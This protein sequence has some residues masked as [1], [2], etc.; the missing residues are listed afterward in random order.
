MSDK[1]EEYSRE[2][3]LRLIRER[4]RKPS[5]GLVWERKEIEH[6]R[7][8]NND[9]VMLEHDPLLSEGNGPH[10]NL[11]IEGDNFDAL[12]YLRMTHAGKVKCIYIDPP[13]NTGNKD[14]IYNDRF[15]DKDDVYKHSKW[16]EFMYRRL[17]IAKDLLANN[18]V[19]LVSINDENKAKLELLM[20]G[21]FPQMRL[22]SLVWR[23]K[24]TGNDLSQRYS[25]VHEHVL[26]YAT[27]QFRF[28]GKPTDRSKFRNPDSDPRGDWSP[29]P[30]TKAHTFAERGN[31]YYPIQNPET[32]YWY[33]CDPNRV[34][35]YASEN[36]IRK[37]VNND[38]V[39]LK[40]AL[41]ALRSDS[42]EKLIEKNLIYFPPCKTSEVMFFN[43]RDELIKAIRSGKGPALPKKKT[44]LLSEDLPD[45]DFWVGKP[46]A[47]GR[48]SRKE[49]WSAKPEE[50]R[51][52][53][54]CSWIGGVNEDL[55]DL[56]DEDNDH[57]VLRTT[58]GGVATE[59]VKDI[60]G[61][62]AFQH[63]KPLSLLEGLL[64]QSAGSDDLVMDF[65][66]GSG[67]T[68]HALMKLNAIDGGNRRFILV[69]SSEATADQPQKN[70]C[71]D[72][73]AERLRRVIVGYTNKKSETVD[74]LGSEFAYMRTKRIP[75]SQVFNEI[76]HNQVW[77]A[78]QLIHDLPLADFDEKVA[79][80]VAGNPD[81]HV[82]YLAKLEERSLEQIES[83]ANTGGL[84]TL[85]SWQPAQL[86]QRIHSSNVSFEKIP[87]FL[88]KRFGGAA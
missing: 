79:L 10:Q 21:V 36:E 8:I 52:A 39:S 88:V 53:P 72:V 31:T 82:V 24:D 26:V 60:L 67:T 55:D 78:L 12:R 37:R 35:A 32:G 41:E 7:S 28:N 57:E 68:G 59:E 83:V 18:G 46:I 48:P 1:Y 16:L 25:H 9:F 54:L 64:A 86:R 44:Q 81:K 73:C 47:T 2:E 4:D 77:R 62:K 30:L 27:P 19:I 13:Y 69:S 70:I 50:E 38:E 45:L 66:A 15:I 61:F 49:L 65:F 75:I 17:V 3:L 63:P 43:S 87:E 11:V 33:P 14:F 42:I 40:A 71:R 58:R 29:Q 51:L 5:F 80:Q 76:Q 85:Y 23:T 84:I 20:D 22:G 74:G 6:E 56:I 34:W